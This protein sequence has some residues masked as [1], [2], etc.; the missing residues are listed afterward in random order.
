MT[1]NNSKDKPY[2]TQRNNRLK[3]NGA[4]NVSAM[5]AALSAAG[6]AVE[7]LGTQKYPQPEDSLMDFILSSNACQN[8]WKRLDPCGKC[9][10]NEWHPVLAYGTNL[11]LESSG[12]CSKNV[13]E[14]REDIFF[15][16]IIKNIDAGGSYVC[17]GVF[18]AQGKKTIGHVV[19]VVGYESSD[20][21]TDFI[22]D[23]SWGDY[24]TEYASHN[25]NDVKMPLGDFM[26]LMRPCGFVRKMGHF[27]RPFKNGR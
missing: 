14:W 20:E 15:S 26:R 18:V 12:L 27:V 11:W 16:D 5:V 24:H 21:A 17:S 13:V 6:W 7:T 8:M 9:P 3:P 22:I 23:D 19:A 1:K 4:C 2:Y 25:G 10:P